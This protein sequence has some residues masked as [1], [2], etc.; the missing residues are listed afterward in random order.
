MEFRALGDLE[1]VADGQALALGPHQQRAVL[2]L[3]VLSTG[4]VVSSDRLIEALWGERPPASAAKTV[5]VY[6]S[7]LRK[8]LNGA[9]AGAPGSAGAIATVDHGYALRVDPGQVDVRA[10]ER[11]LDRGRDAFGDHEFDAAAT[12]LRQALALWRG[13]PLADFTFDA[14]AAADIARLQELRLEALEIRID[15]DLA[16]GRHAALVAELEALTTEHP[17]RE[18]LRAA[19]ML[20]LY[21]C[22]REP[23]ALELYRDTRRTLVDE[24]GMEPSPALRE[25]HESILRQDP[26]LEAPP[27]PQPP[28]D[29]ASDP[30]VRRRRRAAVA[31]AALGLVGGV[32]AV[33]ALLA[34]GGGTRVHVACQLRGGDRPAQPPATRRRLGGHAAWAA[35]TGGRIGV[36]G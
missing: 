34:T 3:L 11:L 21:R 20:A 4:E 35:G 27:A 31:A 24:L 14:F 10:F 1:V 28:G 32:A 15:A 18:R 12:V 26:A 8:T 22:G 36:G 33:I 5:Q 17:L 9:Q 19:R 25:L 13:P 2:A 23:E 30:R 6:I 16:L 7:R 29:A